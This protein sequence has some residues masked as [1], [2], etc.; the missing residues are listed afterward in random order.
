MKLEQ[1]SS[2]VGLHISESFAEAVIQPTEDKG[3]GLHPALLASK[4]WYLPRKTIAD[5]LKELLALAPPG[6]ISVQVIHNSLPR[7]LS[8]QLGKPPAIVVNS[9]FE[10]WLPMREPVVSSPFATK[11]ERRRL[12]LEEDFVFGA[13]GRVGSSGEVIKEQ[14]LEEIDFIAA[15]LELAKI[16]DVAIVLLHSENNPEHENL[17]AGRLREKGFRTVVSHVFGCGAKGQQVSP[18]A[19]VDR[20]RRTIENAFATSAFADEKAQIESAL[21]SLA[22]RQCELRFWSESGPLAAS[23][24][25]PDFKRNGEHT[26]LTAAFRAHLQP[27]GKKPELLLHCGLDGFSLLRADDAGPAF[28][29]QLRPTAVIRNGE[30]PF[31]VISEDVVG[32]APGPMA[33]GKSQQLTVFD[34]FYALENIQEIDGLSSL[35]S[36]RSRGRILE[37]LLSLAKVQAPPNTRIVPPDPKQI[38]AGITT[39]FVERCA[40][41]LATSSITPAAEIL[42]SGPLAASFLAPLRNRRSDLKINLISDDIASGF[43]AA[44]SA[45]GGES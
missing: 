38:A 41:A 2:C 7:I 34:I 35:I 39:A 44:F 45:A 29:P 10:S 30:W 8:K 43:F 28:H 3:P 25:D 4:R 31:P 6:P 18:H 37:T 26:A 15:K 20:F 33:F 14:P 16:K 1:M 9:G 12:P 42:L 19:L 21:K 40:L 13:S 32:W 24:G 5:G 36:D 17:I 27:R 23:E 22:D 11:T